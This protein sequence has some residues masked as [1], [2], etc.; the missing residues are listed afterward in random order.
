VE[1]IALDALAPLITQ[2]VAVRIDAQAIAEFAI[3][4]CDLLVQIYGRD[5]S[6]LYNYKFADIWKQTITTPPPITFADV[7]LNDGRAFGD[8]V[9]PGTAASSTSAFPAT[10]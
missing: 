8:A 7:P 2:G 4:R 5:G 9:L 1:A 3:D 10:R 6:Q